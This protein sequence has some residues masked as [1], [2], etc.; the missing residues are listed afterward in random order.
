MAC[1]GSFHSHD[2]KIPNVL[3]KMK[4]T[5]THIRAFILRA[6]LQDCCYYEE[7]EREMKKKQM[8]Y[9]RINTSAVSARV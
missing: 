4:R 3:F 6:Q 7:R 9:T 2:I 1:S 5:N 8:L